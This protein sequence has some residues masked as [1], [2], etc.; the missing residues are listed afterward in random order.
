RSKMQRELFKKWL[1]NYRPQS[2]YF[3]SAISEELE[4]VWVKG[5]KLLNSKGANYSYGG[6]QEVLDYGLDSIPM[7][8]INNV[9]V[10]GMGGGCVV[11]SL[12]NK[13]DYH[14]PIV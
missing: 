1:S 10:L 6:L 13:Y 12:R 8:N 2:H 5:K 11:D 4:V 9:L 3:S 7:N 14:G